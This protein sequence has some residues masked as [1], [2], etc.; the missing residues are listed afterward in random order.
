M[1]IPI[2]SFFTFF[3]VVVNML[4]YASLITPHT[5]K[6]THIM[7]VKMLSC[8]MLSVIII[9]STPKLIASLSESN[10]IPY[11]SWS[12]RLLNL[13]AT[14]PSNASQIAANIKQNIEYVVLILKALIIPKIA[15]LVPVIVFHTS[16][17]FLV[18]YYITV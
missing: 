8:D 6:N 11:I 18:L 10:S 2:N 1:G 5:Q 4:K 16:H 17:R 15:K 7:Y 12:F 3:L 14:T 9:G 13:L